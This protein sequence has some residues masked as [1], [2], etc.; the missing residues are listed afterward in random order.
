[1]NVY[2]NIKFRWFVEYPYAIE[3]SKV[4]IRKHSGG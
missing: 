3:I 1:M 2:Y 4:S